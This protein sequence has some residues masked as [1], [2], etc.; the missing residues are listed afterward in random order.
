MAV[1]PA[2][3]GMILKFASRVAK[4]LRAPRARGDDPV[5][6]KPLYVEMACSP[7]TRG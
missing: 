6:P 2:H 4:T 1:L 3:A 7:R 5:I